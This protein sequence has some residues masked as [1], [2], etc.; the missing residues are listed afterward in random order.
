[1]A[2][3]HGKKRNTSISI[4][5]YPKFAGVGIDS[6]YD[7]S[8][9]CENIVKYGNLEILIAAKKKNCPWLQVELYSAKSGKPNVLNWMH[10]ND[11]LWDDW[12]FQFMR[13][14]ESR[15]TLIKLGKST[16]NSCWWS[17][18]MCEYAVKVVI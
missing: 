9:V 7:I 16:A 13:D 17:V 1:M 4:L 14:V 12:N 3:E 6:R 8:Y 5:N 10:S 2:K 15:E 18:L 11:L